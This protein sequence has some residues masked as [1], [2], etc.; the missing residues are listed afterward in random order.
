MVLL[1]AMQLGKIIIVASVPSVREYVTDKEVIFYEPGN[2]HDLS[3]KIADVMIKIEEYRQRGE[4]AR[5]IYTESFT[6]NALLNR[7]L[8]IV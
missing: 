8:Q 4:N 2:V 5:R 6:F 7:T 3:D 1:H